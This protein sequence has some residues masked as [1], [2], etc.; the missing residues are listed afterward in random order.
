[1]IDLLHS[2]YFTLDTALAFSY[3]NGTDTVFYRL[4]DGRRHR[5]A[6]W[7]KG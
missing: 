7:G 5:F 2:E 3:T 4:P 6:Q 1:M